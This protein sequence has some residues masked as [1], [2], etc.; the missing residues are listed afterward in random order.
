MLALSTFTS[1]LKGLDGAGH[2]DVDRFTSDHVYKEDTILGLAM[3]TEQDKWSLTLSLAKRYSLPLWPVYATHLQTLLTSGLASEEAEELVQE[4][5]LMTVLRNDQ[6]KLE[7]WMMTRVLPLLDG[8]DIAMLLLYHTLLEHENHVAAL[9]RLLENSLKINF[10]LLEEGHKDV[11]KCVDKDNIHTLA[12]VL[13]IIGNENV[14]SSKIYRFWAFEVFIGHGKS[15][16]NWIEAFSICQEYMEKMTPEDSKLF[17]KD[18]ILSPHAFQVVPKPARGRIFK[19]SIKFV[20]IKIAGKAEGDWKKLE[21]WLH[22]VK[23]HSEMLKSQMSSDII[24]EFNE[25]ELA[26]I[27]KLEMTAGDVIEIYKLLAELIVNRKDKELVSGIV[28]IWQGDSEKITDG[29][30][31]LLKAVIDQVIIGTEVISE[32][33]YVV[34]ENICKFYELPGELVSPLLSPLC[35]NDMVPV[36]NRLSLVKTLKMMEIA[37]ETPSEDLDSSMLATLFETQQD[38]VKILPQF[39]VDKSDL[40]DNEA[41]WKLLER[42]VSQCTNAQQLVQ[43][44]ELIGNWE[45]F[46]FEHATDPERNCILMIGKKLLHLESNG[47]VLVNLLQKMEPHFAKLFPTNIAKVLLQH[48]ETLKNKIVFVKLVFFLQVEENYSEALQVSYNFQVSSR[49]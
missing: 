30:I 48:C 47:H 1:F 9:N 43:T 8:E 27:D 14:T 20:E 32:D 36:H 13:D 28:N 10:T 25:E 2:V 21:E 39:S 5:D 44:H 7:S 12:E 6:E 31:Q 29:Y 38:L 11:F 16:D 17:I 24:K 23:K 26:Y 46:E 15:K 34:M 35:T 33:P 41:K 37:V 49:S 4:R 42:L 45:N 22:Q 18:C 19:K 3:F 40:V